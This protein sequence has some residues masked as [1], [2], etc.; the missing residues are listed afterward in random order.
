MFSICFKWSSLWFATLI[1]SELERSGDFQLV[2]KVQLLVKKLMARSRVTEAP[3]HQLR[4]SVWGC[5]ATDEWL[6]MLGLTL[7]PVV[8]CSCLKCHKGNSIYL[9]MHYALAL[10]WNYLCKI[11]TVRDLTQLT[12]SCFWLHRLAIFALYWVW[13]KLILGEFSLQFK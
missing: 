5:R 9:P 4:M 8:H 12:P 6:V 11:M 1:V 13:A 7:S 3:S 10:H 2:V